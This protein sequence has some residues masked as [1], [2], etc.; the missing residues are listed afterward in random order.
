M[1]KKDFLSGATFET[2]GAEGLYRYNGDCLTCKRGEHIE[3][4]S[5]KIDVHSVGF[6]VETK[7]INRPIA[8]TILYKNCK[9]IT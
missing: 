1:K 8:T 2:I 5:S 4:V 3:F 7:F 6:D 9:I